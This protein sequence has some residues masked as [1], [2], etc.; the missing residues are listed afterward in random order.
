MKSKP[1]LKVVDFTNSIGQ[2]IK[3]GDEVVIVTS[4]YNHDVHINSGIY[5]GRKGSK[6]GVSCRVT[7]H[8]TH[9]RH[10][11]TGVEYKHTWYNDPRVKA[12]VYPKMDYSHPYKSPEYDEAYKVYREEYE[13][14][15]SQIQE[16]GKEYEPFKVPYFR[17]TTLQ[18]NRI[19]K[20]DTSAIDI[21]I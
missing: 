18:K 7:E 13:K 1:V 6:D 3:P 21:K 8:Y 10:K 14:V 12:M 5:L 17:Y 4:G 2:V 9:Y 15:T 19:F 16:I 20:I 11:E